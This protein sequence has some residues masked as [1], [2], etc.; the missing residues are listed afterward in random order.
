MMV[1]V[2]P[3]GQI[4]SE[5]SKLRKMVTSPHLGFN[6]SISTYGGR[7]KRRRGEFNDGDDPMGKGKI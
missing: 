3:V 1:H 6:P 4:F 2:G 5:P 7:G